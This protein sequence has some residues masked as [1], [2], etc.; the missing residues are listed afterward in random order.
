MIQERNKREGI[1]G[2]ERAGDKEEEHE[3]REKEGAGVEEEVKVAD[4]RNSKQR[5]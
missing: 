3:G 4:C 1:E 2:K 5:Q